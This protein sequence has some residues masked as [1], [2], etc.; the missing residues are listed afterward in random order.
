MTGGRPEVGP[1]LT[2]AW[3]HT[4]AARTELRAWQDARLRRLVVHAYESVPLDRKLFDLHRLHPRHIRGT[5]DLEL[6]PFTDKAELCRQGPVAVLARGHDPAALLSVR[7]SGSSG[8]PFT[9]RRTWLE[10]KLQ[11][12]LRLRAFRSF[13]VKPRDRLVAVGDPGR[14]ATGDQKLVGRSLRAFGFHQSTLIDGLQDP[15]QVAAQLRE[16]RPDVLVG[17]AGMLDRL[18]APELAEVVHAVRPRVVIVGGEWRRRP[19]GSGSARPSPR[20]STRPMPATSAPSWP[21]SAT[22]RATCTP[23]TTACWSRCCATARRWSPAGVARW[24]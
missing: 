3:R 9:V 17:L 13:G 21:G 8:E 2:A 19:C 11:Y 7:T 4:R 15:A 1:A 23:A 14:P 22:T 5:V 12:L 10:D 16:A 6:I 18:T 24:W 20:R